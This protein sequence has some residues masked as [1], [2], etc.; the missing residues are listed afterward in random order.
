MASAG[1][2]GTVTV[3]VQRSYIKVKNLRGKIPKEIHSA[4][5]E[6]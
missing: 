3:E 5:R 4:L 2:S 1:T 6:I